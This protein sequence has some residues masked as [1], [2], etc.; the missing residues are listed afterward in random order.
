MEDDPVRHI[1]EKATYF[2]QVSDLKARHA[3]IVPPNGSI[4]CLLRSVEDKVDKYHERL[5]EDYEYRGML[6]RSAKG[7]TQIS[8]ALLPK[9]RHEESEYYH[10]PADRRK[11]VRN[12]WLTIMRD[13]EGISTDVAML[14]QLL[15]S[16]ANEQE[17]QR[18]FEEHPAILMQARLGI[19]VAHPTLATPRRYS[20][21]VAFTPVLGG[22]H[23][24]PVDLLELKGPDAAVLNNTKRHRG[25]SS[26]LHKA[27]D[28]VRDYG[29]YLSNLE[30]ATRLIQKLGYLPTTPQMAVLIGRGLKDDAENEIFRRREAE[31]LDVKVI[32]YDDILEGQT[33]QLSNRMI[34]PGDDD[35]L[36]LTRLSR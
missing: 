2:E 3:S 29:R 13:N 30:N 20:P 25:F 32:T 1:G 23:G 24:D 12:R 11:H 10:V 19:P 16:N 36:D 27:I 7:R 22:M 18:F 33:R 6:V 5:L 4:D 26:A 28:Q 8:P 35:F 15:N 9:R 17:M 21:D 31:Q 34:L 14:E